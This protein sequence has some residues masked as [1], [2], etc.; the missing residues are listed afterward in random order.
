MT[1]LIDKTELSDGV[2]QTDETTTTVDETT[3]KT[4]TQSELDEIVAKR[5]E[6]ERKKTE[7]FADYD[8]LKTKASEYEAKLEEQRLAELSATER[9]EELAKKYEAEKQELADLLDSERTARSTERIRNEFIKVASSAGI[10]YVDDA[11]ALS[12]LS[13]VTI[14]ET[15]AIVGV[16]EIVNALVENKPFLLAQKKP[17][18]AIGQATNNATARPDKTAEQLLSEA[19]AKARKSGRTED[20]IA[21]DRLKRELDKY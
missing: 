4:F 8:E 18:Q 7:K 11:I 13:A 2:T 21:F 17:Q 3:P 16:G 1:E 20:R 10:E 14:D 9:A 5:I 19:A 6:R 12:D 15:G